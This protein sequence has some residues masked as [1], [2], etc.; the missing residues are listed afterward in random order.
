MV[1]LL[2]FATASVLKK[3]FVVSTVFYVTAALAQSRKCLHSL[4]IAETIV[5]QFALQCLDSNYIAR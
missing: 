5:F 4:N 1:M 3:L 2:M